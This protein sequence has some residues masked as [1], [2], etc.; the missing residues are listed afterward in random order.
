[1]RLFCLILFVMCSL[2][3]YSQ[4]QEEKEAAYAKTI[5]VRAEKIV[6]PLGISDS[7]K[8]LRVRDLI[9][10]QYRS[11]NDVYSERDKKMAAA[12]ELKQTKKE[13]AQQQVVNA[14]N[15]VSARLY[16]LHFEFLSKLM[17]FLTPNQIEQVKDGM[18]YGILE[19]T[20]NG[21]LSMIQNLTENQKLQIRAWLTEAREHAMDAGSSDEKHKCFG[22]YKGRINNWLSASGYDLKKEGEDWQK[23]IKLE[24]NKSKK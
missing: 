17:L 11:L 15:E 22:K 7:A 1:M 21:Y 9:I 12:K 16:T 10:Q 8:A 2:T 6:A 18:T 14:E 23:R 13:L 19:L 3:V 4:T 24:E 5:L 20:Y